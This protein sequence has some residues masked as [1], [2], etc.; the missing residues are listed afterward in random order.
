LAAETLAKDMA[1]SIVDTDSIANSEVEAEAITIILTAA[2]HGEVIYIEVTLKTKGLVI[3][4]TTT[5]Y[6]NSL[7]STIS[8]IKKATSLH[9]IL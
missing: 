9:N 1:T 5:T 8:T 2:T 3:N 6:I 4:T 7:E